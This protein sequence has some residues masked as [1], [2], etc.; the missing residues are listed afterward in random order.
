[1]LLF[2]GCPRSSTHRPG[3]CPVK[4][5]RLAVLLALLPTAC[6]GSAD[7]VAPA[8]TCQDRTATNFGG[9]LPCNIPPPIPD[10]Q[11]NHTGILVL[12][13]NSTNLLPREADVDGANMGLIPYGNR[14]SITVTAGVTHNVVFRN[15]SNGAIV[16][17]AQPIVNQCSTF[18][19][20]NTFSVGG[21]V[22]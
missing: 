6:T 8:P 18:T 19:L 22:Q 16:S 5:A 17:T 12:T 13:N 1:M 9:P 10:C 20:N 14:I 3:K 4:F 11:A 7:P 2:N 21:P 15:P